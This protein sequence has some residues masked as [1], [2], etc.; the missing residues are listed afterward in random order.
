LVAYPVSLRSV[1]GSGDGEGGLVI[2]EWP[3]GI[4]SDCLAS[5]GPVQPVKMVVWDLDETLWEGTLSE[6]PVTIH[7]S[8]IDLVRALNRRGIVNSICSKNDEAGARAQL[9]QDDLWS[10]FV[11]ARIDWSPKGARVARI[12]EDAQ[13][14]PADVLFIDDLPLNREEVRHAVPGIQT[15][16]P[17][18]VDRLLTLPALS[19]KDDRELSRLSQYRILEEKLVD[20]EAVSDSNEE[21]L[22]SCAIR[23]GVFTDTDPQAERLFELMNRTNQLNFT[24]RRPDWE[25]FTAMLADPRWASGYVQV[26]DRYGDY[27]ICGFYSVSVSDNVL[28]DFLFSC[29]VLHMGVE[30]WMYDYLGRPSVSVVGEVASSLAESVDWITLDQSAFTL[31]PGGSDHRSGEAV[32][33][34]SQPNRILMVGGCDLTTTA[35]FLGGEIVTEFS[36]TGPTGAFIYVGHSE[37]LRQSAVGISVEQSALVDRIPFLDRKVFSSPA[38]VAP[39]YDVLVYSV[40]TDFTQGLYR[41]RELGLVVPWHQFNVDVTDP[42]NWPGF[43]RRFARE[44]MG[45]EFFEWFAQEFECMGG[46]SVDRFQENIRWLATSIP[47]QA[48]LILLNGSEVP[49]EQTK[50]PDRHLHHK[51]M[52]AALDS[53]AADLPNCTVCD[54]RTFVRTEDDLRSDIR[55]YRRH[56]YLRLAE[57]IRAAGGSHL[58]VQPDRGI[59]R[60]YRQ[61]YAFAGR[62][63][64]QCRRLARRVRRWAASRST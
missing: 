56:I 3:E 33:A 24:K 40:L 48:N 26:R 17:E 36:H 52:N 42:A 37:T 27:G 18:I 29:R 6:G 55:H 38:V 12:V 31:G 15:A 21:F 2:D 22:R 57:E 61:V 35:Q 9:E 62:R 14:R 20:R 49:M 25:E 63:K 11:F 19:G 30:Q 16:G 32:P 46:I 41:H 53:V 43:E 60:A 34:L 47:D 5:V 45:R 23:I 13:L 59:V 8:R 58:T 64:V 50:E 10:Q 1:H 51:K 7:P 39:D 4:A 28:T 44:G 54:V